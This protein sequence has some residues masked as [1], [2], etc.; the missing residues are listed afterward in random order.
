MCLRKISTAFH[1]LNKTYLYETRLL[2]IFNLH[3]LVSC[4][5]SCVAKICQVFERLTRGNLTVKTTDF[6]S[7]PPAENRS[8]SQDID[9]PSK[10]AYKARANRVRLTRKSLLASYRSSVRRSPSTSCGEII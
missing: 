9:F 1:L 3:P 5:I 10:E 8:R 2:E 4:P 6:T 7:N